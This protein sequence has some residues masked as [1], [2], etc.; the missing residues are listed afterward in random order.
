MQINKQ[1]SA[2]NLHNNMQ[3]LNVFDY[4]FINFSSLNQID[5]ITIYSASYHLTFVSR[6]ILRLALIFPNKP[7]RYIASTINI[8]K[9]NPRPALA[10]FS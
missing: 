4:T 6:L 8:P 5:K 3:I 7:E 10:I 2:Y 9:S 1:E